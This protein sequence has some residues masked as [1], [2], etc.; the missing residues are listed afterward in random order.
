MTLEVEFLDQFSQIEG[1]SSGELLVPLAPLAPVILLLGDSHAESASCQRCEDKCSSLKNDSF[2]QKLNKFAQDLDMKCDVILEF[3][4]S[5]SNQMKTNYSSALVYQISNH[6]YETKYSNLNF[7]QGDMRNYRGPFEEVRK[8]KQNI[9]PVLFTAYLNQLLMLK[10][11]E[12]WRAILI[13]DFAPFSFSQILDEIQKE[14]ENPQSWKELINNQFYIKFSQAVAQFWRLKKEIRDVFCEIAEY[15]YPI[16]PPLTECL[17]II[18]SIRNNRLPKQD[19]LA[20]AISKLYLHFEHKHVHPDIF[21]ISRAMCSK[22][23]FVVIYFGELHIAAMRK[24]IYPFYRSV[25][26]FLPASS[27]CLVQIGNVSAF[28]HAAFC[29]TSKFCMPPNDTESVEKKTQFGYTL[30]ELA[31]KHQY[32][33]SIIINSMTDSQLQNWR[34]SIGHCA[35]VSAIYFKNAFA[36]KLIIKRLFG[37]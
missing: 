23:R 31:L 22:N 20:A 12:K 34:S 15:I 8:N 6:K 26:L 32:G 28:D 37:F 35:I 7:I 36:L 13:K 9:A 10:S 29:I 27:N 5:P 1:P 17:S 33:E 2:W 25:K 14:L 21:S 30:L 4:E 19:D 16:E 3:G 18:E 11:I 24:L